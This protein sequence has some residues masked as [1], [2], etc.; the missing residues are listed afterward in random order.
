[1][2]GKNLPQWE[3]EFS[4]EAYD[5]SQI[6]LAAKFV[7]TIDPRGWPHITFIVANRAKTPTQLVWGQFTEGMSKNNVLN[8][9]KQGILM[10]TAEMPFRFIQAK[11]EFEYLKR[12]GEDVEKFS[13]MEFI[14]YNTY[15]NIHTAYYN[16]VIAVTQVRNL[17]LLGIFKGLLVNIVGSSGPKVKNPDQKLPQFAYALFN[18]KI[19]P[20]FIC[21][22]DPADGYPL[23]I[24]CFQ[25]R[26]PDPSRLVFTLSQFKEELL[27]IP[28]E[29]HVA[30]FALNLETMSNLVNGTFT[31]FQKTRGIKYGIIEIDEVYNTMPPL[32]GVIY[33]K[34]Q[35]RPKVTVFE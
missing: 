4:K 27:Q 1:M 9:S 32:P 7:A 20:K 15:M 31:G 26:A 14:R 12:E 17:S 21:Y 13:R 35:I 3:P 22:I 34:L 10:M 16:R 11:V 29:S 25:L 8:N 28:T 2:S 33:P 23:I 6:E 24:P 30:A 18:A 5:L 19:G